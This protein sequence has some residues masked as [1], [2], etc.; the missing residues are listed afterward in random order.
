VVFGPPLPFLSLT[1]DV[2]RELLSSTI[3]VLGQAENARIENAT[4]SCRDGK[5]DNGKRGKY[6][7]W[8]IV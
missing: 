5:S 4:P 2:R 3:T 7:V 8:K 6:E 1:R